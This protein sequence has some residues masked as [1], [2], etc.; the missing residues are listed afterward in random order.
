MAPKRVP[1]P[2]GTPQQ[3]L[4]PPL[5]PT[6]SPPVPLQLPSRNTWRC[7][8]CAE[9]GSCEN[10]PRRVPWKAGAPSTPD[11][12]VSLKD[13]DIPRE[14]DKLCS[15]VEHLVKVHPKHVVT[16]NKHRMVAVDNCCSTKIK[17]PKME[18]SAWPYL[19]HFMYAHH[20]PLIHHL[21]CPL[22]NQGHTTRE[23]LRKC[24]TSSP[25]TRAAGNGP[26]SSTKRSASATR[27]RVVAPPPPPIIAVATPPIAPAVA[28]GAGKPPSP[29]VP[30]FP[31]ISVTPPAQPDSPPESEPPSP[32]PAPKPAGPF[33]SEDRPSPLRNADPSLP[34][35]SSPLDDVGPALPGES[36]ERAIGDKYKLPF[37]EADA[38]P[39]RAARKPDAG[40]LR[41]FGG[42]LR[43]TAVV[44]GI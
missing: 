40:R 1:A 26:G 32:T 36:G 25:K 39:A 13:V 5:L 42:Y 35:L 16:R 17:R 19:E 22:C 27:A 10:L 12:K 6:P 7:P 21:Q 8:I 44:L 28:G 41:S 14:M 2:V 23:E 31:P 3:A 20:E 38:P 15:L 24:V 33:G 18:A 4:P 43:R 37:D 11:A 9:E 29:A 30:S 34:V